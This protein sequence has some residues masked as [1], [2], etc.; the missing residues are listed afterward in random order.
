MNR[1]KFIESL[2]ATCKNWNWS[3]SFINENEK[4]VIFGAWDIHND[5]NMSLILCEKWKIKHDGKKALGYKQS[6]EHIRL[7]EEEGYKLLTFPMK[8]SD[9]NKDIDG[10]GPAKIGGFTAKATPKELIKLEGAWYASDEKVPNRI[11][12]EIPTQQKYA[13]GSVTKIAINAYER[14]GEARKACLEF[15]GYLCQVCEFDFEE[16]YGDIGKKYIHVHHIIPI[17]EIQTEYFIDPV[18]DLIPVCPNC[19]AML[20]R[21]E[22][23]L[24][25]N[26]LKK[27]VSRNRT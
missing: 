16:K 17:S 19:H 13:E 10:S 12:E 23:A 5:G 1:K 25:V 2:G 7:I 27:I 9:A 4:T 20:H 21:T 14:N 15:H 11:P 18:K 3:W 26:E 8:Y 22:P 6:R 24:T